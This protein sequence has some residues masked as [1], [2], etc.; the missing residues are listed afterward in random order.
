MNTLSYAGDRLHATWIWRDRFDKTSVR[1]QHDL[2][3]AYSD[4]HGRTWHNS[5]G[6]VIGK[7]GSEPIHLK[8][9]GLVVAPIPI[10]SRLSNQN[11]HYAHEDGRIHIVMI[12]RRE[13]RWR[14]RYQH[15]WRGIDGVWKQ[16]ELPFL[17]SRPKIVGAKDRSLILLFT[18]DDDRLR[19]AMGKPGSDRGGWRWSA[20]RLPGPHS[21]YGDAVLDLERWEEEGMVSIYSQEEPA[22]KIRTRRSD[23]VDGF[24]SPLNVADYRLL[25]GAG[26]P[27]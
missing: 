6:K 22:R 10:N 5:Q 2:C 7:T 4:D 9:P 19:M 13:G 27:Q 20:L 3:Y 25:E 1:N 18:D 12:Q 17:G 11:T 16:E 8:S 24:P 14:S 21:C 23:P 26:S 15:H